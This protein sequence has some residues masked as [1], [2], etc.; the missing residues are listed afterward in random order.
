MALRVCLPPDPN[1]IPPRFKAPPGACDTHCHIFGPP[2]IFPYDEGRRYTPPAAPVE[3]YLDM[4]DAI[5]VERGI[6]VQP[7]CHGTDNRVTLDAIA[8]ADGRLRGVARINDATDDAEI[9]RLH[10]GGIRGVRFEFVAGRAGSSDLALFGRVI[11]RVGAY[12]WCVELHVDPAVLVAN[13]G[14]FRALRVNALVDHFARIQTVDGLGQPAFQLLLELMGRDNYWVKISGADERTGTP[15]PYPEIVPFAHALIE[16]APDRVLWG[17][18][19]P[20]SNIFEAG[21]IPNDGL[22][23]DLVPGFAPDEAVRRKI[24]VDNPSK[25][26]GFDS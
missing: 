24:L 21:H 5:G 3:H 9:A 22:L 11:E 6:V 16:C 26:F 18:N 1:P 23:L 20:H 10:E 13:A 8:R 7:N 2:D 4:L 19:W 14:W 17:T 15:Y 12:G 25:L